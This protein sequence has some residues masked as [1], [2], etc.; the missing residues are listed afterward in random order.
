MFLWILVVAQFILAAVLVLSANWN[1]F[2]VV[3]FC[4]SIPGIGLAV[5][6]WFRVG[7][8][9]VRIHP[10]STDRT[11]FL[12]DGPYAI[13]RHPM[14]TGLLWFTAALLSEPF[15]WWRIAAW[16]VLFAVLYL[17]S[18]HEEHSMVQRFEDYAQYQNRVGRLLPRIRSRSRH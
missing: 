13:V 1:P 12:D 11:V 4:V 17:K 9:R 10:E 5:W 3:E 7:L 14:Y 8:T 15:R 18:G 16:I 6:A 2:P